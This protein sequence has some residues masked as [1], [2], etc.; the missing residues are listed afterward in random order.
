M[1][2]DMTVHVPVGCVDEYTERGM[3]PGAQSPGNMVLRE[4]T[5]AF[6]DFPKP[7][8]FAINGLAVGG[9]A[10]IALANY[11]DLVV[12][13]TNARFKWPFAQLGGFRA[14]RESKP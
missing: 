11:G 9:G 2:G 5:Q 7:V 4:Q 12:C 6:W 1:G 13:S 8:I 10:N 3:M 14:R